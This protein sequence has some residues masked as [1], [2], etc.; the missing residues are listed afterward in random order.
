MAVGTGTQVTVG[1]N[2]ARARQWGQGGGDGDKAG[3]GGGGGGSGDGVAVGP[4][5]V[6]QRGQEVAPGV[7]RCVTRG[8]PALVIP[9][10]I[11]TRGEGPV[12]V[13]IPVPVPVPIPRDS[14]SLGREMTSSPRRHV[15]GTSSPCPEDDAFSL[16]TLRR[17]T[18]RAGAEGPSCTD[19]V[20]SRCPGAAAAA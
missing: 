15:V 13:L 9:T 16:P 2:V 11:H 18:G 5:A 20:G 8:W 14:T 6:A 10:S 19:T 4:R 17:R 7:G 12:S 3:D 1:E